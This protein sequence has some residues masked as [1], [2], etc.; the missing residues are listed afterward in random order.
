MH[1]DNPVWWLGRG[2]GVQEIGEIGDEDLSPAMLGVAKSPS[3]IFV[4]V[5][6]GSKC[7]RTASS[8][9]KHTPIFMKKAG[10]L[11][12][13]CFRTRGEGGAFTTIS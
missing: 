8:C 10:K 12:S 11:E 9:Q 6:L 13:S 5:P 7:R 3:F 2:G 4:W 1:C